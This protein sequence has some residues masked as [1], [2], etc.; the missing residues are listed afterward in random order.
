MRFDHFIDTFQYSGRVSSA[1]K[2]KNGCF[3]VAPSRI[4]EQLIDR[5]PKS[6]RAF[7]E[8]A[9]S[10]EDISVTLSKED[11]GLSGHIERLA[12]RLAFKLTIE[13]HEKVLAQRFLIHRLESFW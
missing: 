13:L 3:P 12:G 8:F 11:V 1:I 4:P 2:N 9:F 7:P 10:N 5:I 6:L